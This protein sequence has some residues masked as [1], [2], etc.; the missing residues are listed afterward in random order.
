MERT[1]ALGTRGAAAI[2]DTNLTFPSHPQ[3]GE[4]NR[5]IFE[6][7]AIVRAFPNEEIESLGARATTCGH[8]YDRH[9]VRQNCRN[10][11][12]V[13]VSDGLELEIQAR[14]AGLPRSPAL[15]SRGPA[16]GWGR[17]RG[18]W[19]GRRERDSEE[20]TACRPNDSR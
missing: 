8:T 20:Q 11:H 4:P 1:I 16:R 3:A 14:A 19:V 18:K 7:P 5:A 9:R 15:Q 13:G 2:T 6:A 17:R 12:A 10:W